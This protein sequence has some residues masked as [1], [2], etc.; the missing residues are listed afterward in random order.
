[1]FFSV[2]NKFQVSKLVIVSLFV[3]CFAA[4]EINGQTAVESQANASAQTKAEEAKA[5][6]MP[7][8][9]D[10]KGVKIGMT[11]DEVRDKLGKPEVNDASGYFYIFSDEERAQIGF[12]A[13][14][15]VNMIAVFYSADHE[16]KPQFTDVFGPEAAAAAKPDGSVYNLVQ[17][18]QA[19]YWIAYSRLAGKDAL[20]T[21]TMQKIQPN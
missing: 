19:G 12:D 20:V 18:P 16:K 13:E 2:T 17:Y 5:V 15:K 6:P 21:V 4:I 7:V 10:Y 3:F 11:Q 8:L 1:M 14:K 9:Q